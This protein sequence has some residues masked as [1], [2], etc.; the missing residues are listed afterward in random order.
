M[1]EG[2]IISPERRFISRSP[3]ATMAL[4]AQLGASAF[5]GLVII[6][7]GEL[8]AGKTCFARGFARGLGVDEPVSSPTFA[9][10]NRYEGRLT[11]LHFDAWMEGR[12]RAL[13]ADGGADLIGDQAVT[14]IEW[15]ERVAEDLGES[16]LHILLG[17]LGPDSGPES[18]SLNLVAKGPDPLHGALVAGLNARPGELDEKVA[19][20]GPDGQIH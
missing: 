7:E 12:E 15:G 1:F 18:R 19:G 8:G 9:L 6:L 4:G 17:H 16:Y 13:L 14:L 5:P 3:E 10:M 11:L 2:K 20:G